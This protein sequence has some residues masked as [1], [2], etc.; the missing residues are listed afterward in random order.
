MKK[1]FLFLVSVLLIICACCSSAETTVIRM[2]VGGDA[3][4]GSSEPVRT[5]LYES[6]FDYYIEQYGYSYPF[7][8]LVDLFSADDI[9]LLNL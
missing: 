8:N 1:S 6:S 4:L 3:L 5:K 2:T 7:A 9:T